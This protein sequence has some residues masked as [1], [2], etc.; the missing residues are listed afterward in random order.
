[1]AKKNFIIGLVTFVVI[2]SLWSKDC[3]RTIS[4]LIIWI[5]FYFTWISIKEIE[6][7]DSQ[8]I[9]KRFMHQVVINKWNITVVDL[10]KYTIII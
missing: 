10:K 9:I 3:I 2:A 1:M 4:I 7:T 6:I 8:I 5:A